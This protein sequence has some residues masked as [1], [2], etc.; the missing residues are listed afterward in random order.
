MSD[1]VYIIIYNLLRKTP[2]DLECVLPLVNF[3]HL[4]RTKA[5]KTFS[6]ICF[7]LLYFKHSIVMPLGSAYFGGVGVWGGGSYSRYFVV[8]VLASA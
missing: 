2:L 4:G 5:E 6:L 3:D 8:V 1:A 7:Y